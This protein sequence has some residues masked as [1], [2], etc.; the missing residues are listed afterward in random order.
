M[1]L[2]GIFTS[3]YMYQESA[4]EALS[5]FELDDVLMVNLDEGRIIREM[6]DEATILPP[7]LHR[8]LLRGL[9]V[10]KGN[11]EIDKSIEKRNFL[12]FPS[13]IL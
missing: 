10:R 4:L 9:Q 6:G 3:V 5:S 11:G 7:K 1:T 8:S 13:P 2:T 12:H